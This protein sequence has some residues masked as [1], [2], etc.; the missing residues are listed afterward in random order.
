M[1]VFPCKSQKTTHDLY[2]NTESFSVFLIAFYPLFPESAYWLIREK[3]LDQA[4][5][6]L[7]RMYGKAGT[8]EFIEIEMKRIQLDVDAAKSIIGDPDSEKSRLFG[9]SVASEIECFKGSNRKRTITAIFAASGQQLIGATFV[10]GYAT[11]F[12][13]LINVENFFLVSC[14][15]YVVM[16]I[17]TCAVFGLVEIVGR[18]TLIVPSLFILCVLLLIIGIMGCVPNQNTA[19][20]VI[21]VMIYIWAVIY[22]L[23]IGATGFVLASEVATMRLRAATQALVTVTNGVWGLIM[24]FTIPYMINSDAGN[25]GGKTGFIFFATGSVTAVVG[26]FLFPETKVC[27]VSLYSSLVHSANRGQDANECIA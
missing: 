9:I 18:R 21:I 10:T 16:I 26:Y 22:Q 11:Y 13:D 17:A 3:K 6:A 1:Y 19:G 14:I 20:W 15:L 23:S 8:D 27:L 2:I 7:R 25:L 5:K 12:F 24:Q 4:R